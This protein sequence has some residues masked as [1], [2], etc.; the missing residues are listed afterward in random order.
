MFSIS[1]AMDV[2]WSSDN[3]EL[4]IDGE[5]VVARTKPQLLHPIG[6][7]NVY[8]LRKSQDPTA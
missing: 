6:V 1:D 5:E 2:Y 4:T 8:G 7:E 3:V